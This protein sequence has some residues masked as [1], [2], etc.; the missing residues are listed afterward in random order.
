MSQAFHETLTHRSRIDNFAKEP[1]HGQ[2]YRN[3]P[4]HDETLAS[5]IMSGGD[6]VVIANAEGSRTTPSVVGIT[7]KNE[8]LVGQ[9]AAASHHQSR[10]T[11]FSVK[12]LMGENSRAKKSR[13]PWKRL[14]IKVV[15][16]DNG[17]AHVE[18]RG[19]AVQPAGSSAMIPAEDAA[20]GGRLSPE[21]RSRKPSSRCRASTSMTA[22]ARPRRTPGRS[23]DSTCCASVNEPTA[24]LLATASTKKG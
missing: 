4:R 23:P 11:I 12:R 7:D 20:D 10:N 21:K 6:P 16:A 13:K 17:D 15:E 18:L 8:R 2:S 3:R 1:T 22:N 9:I 14:P 24:A 5:A 19:K